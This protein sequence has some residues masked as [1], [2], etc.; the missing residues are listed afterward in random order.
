MTSAGLGAASGG[1]LQVE[2][3]HLTDRRT[4][5]GH[6]LGEWLTCPPTPPR[7]RRPPPGVHRREEEG[8]SGAKENRSASPVGKLTVQLKGDLSALARSENSL[9]N[10]KAT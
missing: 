5:L 6:L 8:G 2:V 4:P 3:S 10:S 1:S 9:F 7:P